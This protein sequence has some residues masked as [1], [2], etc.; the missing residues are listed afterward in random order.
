MKY[1]TKISYKEL[2]NSFLYKKNAFLF[3]FI[4]FTQKIIKV[5]AFITLFIKLKS[6]CTP[7]TKIKKYIANY[8]LC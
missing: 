3:S 8:Y 1:I 5:E 6:K 7:F 4:L 2:K